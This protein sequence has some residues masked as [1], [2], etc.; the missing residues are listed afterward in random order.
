MTRLTVPE[1]PLAGGATAGVPR[2]V[3]DGVGQA[4]AELGE[5]MIQGG[6]ALEASRLS[7]DLARARV[8]IAN[9]L[10]ELRLDAEGLADPDQIDAA[11]TARRTQLRGDLL[12]GVDP[13]NQEAAGIAFD[14]LAGR[15]GLAI[16]QRAMEL[17]RARA[18]AGMIE[19]GN[20]LDATAGIADFDTRASLM[21]QY[22]DQL[23]AELAQGNYSPEEIPGMLAA[24]REEL[25]AAAAIRTLSEDPARLLAEIDVG[26]FNDL[27]P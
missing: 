27:K 4:F 17:R 12:K 7:A 9:G 15:H 26:R 13:R 14:E 10:A 3:D 6:Q 16:G 25:A 8:G 5:R 20:A 11:W 1:A 23:A 18:R 21:G 2:P 19:L 22:S 24:K